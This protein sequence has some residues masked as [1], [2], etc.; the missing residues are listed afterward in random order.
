MVYVYNE[1]DIGQYRFIFTLE[2]NKIVN[3]DVSKTRYYLGD[4][5]DY[6]DIVT[7]DKSRYVNQDGIKLRGRIFNNVIVI[8]HNISTDEEIMDVNNHDAIAY[9]TGLTLYCDKY[10]FDEEGVI[11]LAM[12]LYDYATIN[13]YTN[14]YTK[15]IIDKGYPRKELNWNL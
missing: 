3:I 13:G 9:P 14:T 11:Y 2:G 6:Y 15:Y 10:E 5:T 12:L 4:A 1:I 8:P 7:T